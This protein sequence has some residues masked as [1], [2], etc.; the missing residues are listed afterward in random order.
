VQ[1][2]PTE[3]SV[4]VCVVLIYRATDQC[5]FEDGDSIVHSKHWYQLTKLYGVITQI[6]MN[7]YCVNLRRIKPARAATIPT[8]SESTSF[9]YR[10][11]PGLSEAACCDLSQFF[12]VWYST[13]PQRC[14]AVCP[15]SFRYGTYPQRC[16]EV[17]PTSFRHDT[18]H[19]VT[20]G[21]LS[22]IFN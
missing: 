16:A 6:V 20:T 10:P 13:Y 19:S 15:S 11:Q 21:T 8:C 7:L 5:T 14:A 12:Q 4:R 2:S 1:S 17:C 9:E 18:S 3:C 22:I